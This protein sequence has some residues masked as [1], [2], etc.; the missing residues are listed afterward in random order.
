MTTYILH[1]GY[2]SGMTDAQSNKL[3]DAILSK[4]N[5]DKIK[6][7]IIPFAATRDNWEKK[8]ESRN[9]SLAKR[10]FGDNYEIRLAYPDTFYGDCDWAN[11]I[12][13]QGGD[14]SLLSHYLDQFSDLAKVFANKI[15]IGS[16]AGADCLS[17][18]FYDGDWRKIG[19]GYGLVDVASIPHFGG[20]YGNDDPR[21]PIDWS[22]AEQELRGATDLP[23]YLIREGEFEVF[24]VES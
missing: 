2:T 11:V 19:K 22:K 7:A 13:I 3:R 6:F 1:G 23:I 5:D 14:Y 10:L 4:L 21:G 15:V 8:F 17:E 16:S 20:E 9:K 24:E 12:F 18:M